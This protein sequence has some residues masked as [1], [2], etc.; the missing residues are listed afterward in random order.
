MREVDRNLL[1]DRIG[2]R[3]ERLKVILKNGGHSEQQDMDDMQHDGSTRSDQHSRQPVD[4]NLYALAQEEL[5]Q[6]NANL[7]WLESDNAGNCEVCGCRIPMN[8][9]LAVPTTRKCI[10][11]A[12][13][14]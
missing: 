4:A 5:N 7:K 3:T 13:G 12:S 11:C 2:L 6:L 14:S 1:L 9:L 10:N 8:R